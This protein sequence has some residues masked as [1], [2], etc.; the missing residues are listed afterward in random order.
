MNVKLKVKIFEK[1]GGKQYLFAQ[2]IGMRETRLSRIIHGREQPKEEEIKAIC[3]EL[4]VRRNE[5][6]PCQ[7]K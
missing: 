2:R 3:S 5:V 4:G 7:D 1:S 6:F